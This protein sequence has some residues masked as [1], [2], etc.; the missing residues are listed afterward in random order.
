MVHG[1]KFEERHDNVLARA[2]VAQILERQPK[3][4]YPPEAAL[5]MPVWPMPSWDKR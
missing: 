2:M 3:L 4:V 5:A 1:V